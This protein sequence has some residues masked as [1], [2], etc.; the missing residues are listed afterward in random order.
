[1]MYKARM[2]MIDEGLTES[3]GAFIRE[4]EIAGTGI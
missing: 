2:V 4:I 1:V 3:E